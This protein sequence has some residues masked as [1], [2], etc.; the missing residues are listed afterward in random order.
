MPSVSRYAQLSREETPI[1]LTHWLHSSIIA[2]FVPAIMEDVINIEAVED[3]SPELLC[4]RRPGRPA[5]TA[6]ELGSA[7]EEKKIVQFHAKFENQEST[8]NKSKTLF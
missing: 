3:S 7:I 5:K 1:D 8:W 4:R 2:P 6:A